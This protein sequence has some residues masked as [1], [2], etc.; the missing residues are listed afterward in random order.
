MY[1]CSF[2]V[3]VALTTEASI[4]ATSL[5]ISLG[6]KLRSAWAK[7]IRTVKYCSATSS[8]SSFGMLVPN[9]VGGYP[10]EQSD[11]GQ[12][13]RAV[14]QPC[15]QTATF[16]QGLL[17]NDKLVDEKAPSLPVISAID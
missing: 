6:G 7:L 2:G 12:C 4:A 14:L 10:Q 9:I 1:V 17:I 11:Q 16:N 5:C 3:S 15:M 8:G 13:N